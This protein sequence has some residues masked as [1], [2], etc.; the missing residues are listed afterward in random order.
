M[1]LSCISWTAQGGPLEELAWSPVLQF[2]S[3]CTIGLA[4]I[5]RMH[6]CLLTHEGA[7]LRWTHCSGFQDGFDIGF[8]DVSS[9]CHLTDCGVELQLCS[10]ALRSCLSTPAARLCWGG[11][12]CVADCV[13][14]TCLKTCK[15]CSHGPR[16]IPC[17]QSF[18]H[19]CWPP[20]R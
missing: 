14:C 10:G 1:R 11:T 18:L 8:V 7:L 3:P 9:K 20:L 19:P 15:V 6:V 12:V 16:E 4:W 2:A 13:S 17:S 5:W